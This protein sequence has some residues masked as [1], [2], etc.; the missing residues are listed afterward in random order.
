MTILFLR[1]NGGIWSLIAPKGHTLV[2]FHRCGDSRGAMEAAVAWV[3]SWQGYEIRF[4][5]E[6]DTKR[7]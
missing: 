1:F 2:E 3:S 6:K 5:D 4:E 7:D